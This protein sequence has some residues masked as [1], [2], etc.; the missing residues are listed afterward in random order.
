VLYSYHSLGLKDAL[1]SKVAYMTHPNL[2]GDPKWKLN[3][4]ASESKSQTSSFIFLP[5]DHFYL[6]L[7]PTLTAELKS[8]RNWKVCVSSNWQTVQS[9]QHVPGAYDFRLQPGENTIVVDAIADLKE[10]D[11]KE[12]A[13]PQMQFDFERIQLVIVLVE[14]STE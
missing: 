11:K 5:A 7:I 9:S 4:Y 6:R 2:P 3:R 12:Y 14:R 1:I 13:P 8:R 10:G